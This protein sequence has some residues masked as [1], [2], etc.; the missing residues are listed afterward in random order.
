[1]AVIGDRRCSSGGSESPLRAWLAK[2]ERRCNENYRR[3][4]PWRGPTSPK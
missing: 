4:L 1:M 3:L 2:S